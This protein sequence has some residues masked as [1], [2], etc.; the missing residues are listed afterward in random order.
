MPGT[1]SSSTSRRARRHSND[2]ADTAGRG[3]G[4]NGRAIAIVPN[5]L[6][7]GPAGEV[8]VLVHFHGIGKALRGRAA[9]RATSTTTSRAADRRLH[10]RQAGH[11]DRR[12]ASRSASRPRTPRATGVSSGNF[13]TDTFINAAFGALGGALP[14]SAT[15]GDVIMSAH[16]G[17][18]L[19]PGAMLT[20]G[21][22]L[23]GRMKGVFLFERRPTRS[24]TRQPA[25]RALDQELPDQEDLRRERRARQAAGGLLRH[26]RQ[27]PR[28]TRRKK[29][30]YAAI[31]RY[32]A[33]KEGEAEA[34]Y[35]K[36]H[37]APEPATVIVG[38]VSAFTKSSSWRVVQHS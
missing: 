27:T 33:K 12:P 26:W 32:K 3:A 9:I 29:Q 38:R 30:I 34:Q 4:A 28:P 16:S 18:G 11:A 6:K 25:D 7:G 5:S 2:V 23:P 31:E 13:N 19:Q 37:P 21:K 8:A 35:T 22:G 24:S 14:S 15:P 17:R 1:R 36:D 20:S 10:G